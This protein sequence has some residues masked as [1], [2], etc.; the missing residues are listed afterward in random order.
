MGHYVFTSISFPCA[1]DVDTARI[2]KKHIERLE[3]MPDVDRVSRDFL[4]ETARGRT[5]SFGAK[6]GGCAYAVTGNYTDL[7]QL[8]R[9]LLPFF[10]DLWQEDLI[11]DSHHALLMVNHEDQGQIELAEIVSRSHASECA[12]HPEHT[13]QRV[14]WWKTPFSWHQT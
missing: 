11:I 2:A 7:D 3:G 6:S 5:V 10:D 1:G 4:N 13:G 8:V 12:K 9:D 14:R